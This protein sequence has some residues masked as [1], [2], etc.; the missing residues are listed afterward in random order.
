MRTASAVFRQR[1]KKFLSIFL[2]FLMRTA[3]AVFRPHSSHY[4]ILDLVSYAHRFGG[5]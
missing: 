5:I 4:C 1:I 2:L 3:S